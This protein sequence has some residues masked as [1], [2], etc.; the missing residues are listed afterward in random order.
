MLLETLKASDDPD[1]LY[2]ECVDMHLSKRICPPSEVAALVG[3]LSS[4]NAGSITGQAFRVDGG[5]GI[6][7]AGN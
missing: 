2:Q 7:I 6:H 1:K 4:D 3:F 5:L